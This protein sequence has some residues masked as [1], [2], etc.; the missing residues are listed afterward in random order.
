M[1]GNGPG[2]GVKSGV[3][4]GDGIRKVHLDRRALEDFTEVPALLGQ[5]RAPGQCRRAPCKVR[6][7][8]ESRGMRDKVGQLEK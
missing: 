8:E 5:G 1:S 3:L 6:T 2:H 7:R 4:N